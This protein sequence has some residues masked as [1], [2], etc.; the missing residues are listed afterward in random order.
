MM[1]SSVMARF[2]LPRSTIWL[3]FRARSAASAPPSSPPIRSSAV[4]AA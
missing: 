1:I 2:S 3:S 4:C